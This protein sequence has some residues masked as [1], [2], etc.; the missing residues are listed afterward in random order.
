MGVEPAAAEGGGAGVGGAVG[1]AVTGYAGHV[2]QGAADHA[3]GAE[4]VTISIQNDTD[5][6]LAYSSDNLSHGEWQQ[7]PPHRINAHS[8]GQAKAT[9]TVVL[10]LA[11]AG[12]T[13]TLSYDV[14]GAGASLVISFDNPKYS[15]S[16]SGS[17][18]MGGAN[19]A[20]YQAWGTMGQGQQAILT[21]GVSGGAPAHVDPPPTHVDPTHQEPTHQEHHDPTPHHAPAH[22]YGGGTGDL[23]VGSHGAEV[24]KWQ[25]ELNHV[26]YAGIAEDGAFGH[27]TQAATIAFQQA[28]GLSAD[29]IVGPRTLAK[30]A[31]LLA[32]PSGGASPHGHEAPHGHE[33]PHQPEY[34][35]AGHDQS[36][37]D[38]TAHEPTPD[39]GGYDQS[40]D[41]SGYDQGASGDETYTA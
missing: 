33:E 12:V 31:Q 16:N 10:G 5:H 27:G 32:D 37:Y 38:H 20:L 8:T 7:P 13:G 29:G 39:P 14:E 24:L 22:H 6:P 11:G 35:H 28:H 25:Q 1:G 17:A 26:A 40:Y 18:Y 4:E 41:A 3:I 36:G 2:A 15:H 34:A 23:M 21:C 9:S 19:G 30:M